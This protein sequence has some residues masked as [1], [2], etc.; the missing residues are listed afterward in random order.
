MTNDD[1]VAAAE[2]LKELV[3][4]REKIRSQILA[5]EEQLLPTADEIAELLNVITQGSALSPKRRLPTILDP[6]RLA[7]V[8]TE[9]VQHMQIEGLPL[10]PACR[11]RI[12]TVFDHL[13]ITTI[14]QL[15]QCTPEDLLRQHHFGRH[16]LLDTQQA[17]AQLGLQLAERSPG[18]NV[19]RKQWK[20][21]PNA[22]GKIDDG[23][24]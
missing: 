5:L 15:V 8:A 3:A 6:P 16:S 17:L 21:D 23:K 2:R 10:R 9:G 24:A 22:E 19:L 18:I 12:L 4:Q 1:P 14:G 13:G 20:S 11:C 7:V